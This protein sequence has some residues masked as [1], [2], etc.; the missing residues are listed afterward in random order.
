MVASAALSLRNSRLGP[1]GGNIA[2]HQRQS[3]PRLCP[4]VACP[5]NSA[6]LRLVLEELLLRLP[7]VGVSCSV[8]V[9][10]HGLTL[11]G[12]WALPWGSILWSAL[13]HMRFALRIAEAFSTSLS[14]NSDL[15]ASPPCSP[16]AALPCRPWVVCVTSLLCVRGGRALV[17]CRIRLAWQLLVP[18]CRSV[19]LASPVF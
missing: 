10:A 9:S 16:A 11:P 3:P 8:L 13:P 14:K 15:T 12:Y 4:A 5:L 17:V 1:L 19:S 18:D 6:F 7:A 2:G